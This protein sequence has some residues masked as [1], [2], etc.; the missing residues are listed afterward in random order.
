VKLLVN[1]PPESVVSLL[2]N[3]WSLCIGMSGHFGPEYT[4]YGS[5]SKMKLWPWGKHLNLF[6][7]IPINLIPMPYMQKLN[8]TL[9]A[10]TS[11]F[12]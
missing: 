8:R 1:F 10:M 4:N 3:H 11:F 5:K 7:M 2:R 9:L 6:L 12:A